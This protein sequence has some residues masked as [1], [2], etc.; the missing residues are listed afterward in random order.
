MSYVDQTQVKRQTDCVTP[1]AVWC[2]LLYRKIQKWLVP[3]FD[4][5]GGETL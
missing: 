1:S 3:I 2:Y 4:I 5:T